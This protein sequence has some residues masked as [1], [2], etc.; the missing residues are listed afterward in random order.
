MYGIMSAPA[1]AWYVLQVTHLNY[2]KPISK[3]QNKPPLSRRSSIET[4]NTHI[5]TPC[6]E[7]FVCSCGAAD[8]NSDTLTC[9][10]VV[11]SCWCESAVRAMS[12]DALLDM[13]EQQMAIPPLF[14][15][16]A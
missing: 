1:D 16:R 8:E 14:T 13:T 3:Q 9:V 11:D 10:V 6:N 12:K 2:L 5:A 15:M 4:Y 7:R